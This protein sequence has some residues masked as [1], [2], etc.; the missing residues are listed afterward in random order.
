M[1]K[2]QKKAFSMLKQ[3][4]NVSFATIK[5]GEPDVRIANIMM[6]DDAG[7]FF[8]AARGKPFYHQLQSS[9]K[10][11]ICGMNKNSVSVRANGSIRKCTGR[12]TIDRI[13]ELHPKM[14]NLYPGNKR[15][16]LEAFC[17]YEGRGEIF[18]L[19]GQKPERERYSF[20]G[21]IVNPAGYKINENCNQCG[22]CLD[23][24][25][26]GSISLSGQPAINGAKCLEC[27]SCYEACPNNAI[28]TATGI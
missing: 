5:N 4:T 24:C 6:A 23:G 1:E 20:G 7:I 9:K 15:E 25:P 18:D 3:I 8:L 26:T 22:A 28:L 27:G 17:M 16:I 12:G 10:A 14:S 11:A 19:S 2:I 21:A 13:F